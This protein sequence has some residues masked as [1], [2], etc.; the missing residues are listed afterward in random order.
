RAWR[1]QRQS[2]TPAN[3]ERILVVEDDDG[4]RR[5]V[6]RVLRRAG[7]RVIEARD[8]QQALQEFLPHA[9]EIDLVLTDVRMPLVKGDELAVQLRAANPTIPVVFM[10]GYAPETIVG[11]LN[12]RDPITILAKPFTNSDL[13][14][15]VQEALSHTLAG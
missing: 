2:R 1:E 13:L 11:T 7:Y 4:V 10:S 14:A 15:V 3:G 12:G 9:K 5:L 8:G 6:Y